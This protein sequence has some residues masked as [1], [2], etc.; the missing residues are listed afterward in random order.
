VWRRGESTR[1]R[2]AT[3]DQLI[4]IPWTTSQQLRGRLLAAGLDSLEDE[5][6][7][8]GASAPIDF[9]LADKGAA[10]RAR[11]RVDRGRG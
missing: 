1:F 6:A 5:F 7:A 11:A 3:S 10:A 2:I 9:D 8:K 4:E